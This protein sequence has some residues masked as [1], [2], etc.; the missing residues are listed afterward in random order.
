MTIQQHIS[1]RFNLSESAVKE[2]FEQYYNEDLD[3]I[4][5]QISLYFDVSIDDIK[6]KS[7]NKPLPLCRQLFFYFAKKKTGRQLVKIAEKVGQ[8]HSNASISIKTI[9]GYLENDREIQYIAK[10]LG[11]LI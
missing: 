2:A 1:N 9:N 6:S 5:L 3:R 10:Q 8:K 7:R 4:L 11:G